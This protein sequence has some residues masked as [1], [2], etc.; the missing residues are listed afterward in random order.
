MYLNSQIQVFRF[1]DFREMLKTFV[2]LSRILTE[3]G[4]NIKFGYCNESSNDI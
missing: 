4:P 1:H 2:K 3:F